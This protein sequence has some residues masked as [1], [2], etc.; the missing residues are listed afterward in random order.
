MKQIFSLKYLI[1]TS[2]GGFSLTSYK[3]F[4]IFFVL[5]ILIYITTIF[6]EKRQMGLYFKILKKVRSFSLSNLLIGLALLFF[7][8]ELIPIL[9]A[10]FWYVI[11]LALMIFWIYLIIKEYLKIPDKKQKIIEAKEFKKYLP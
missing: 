6:L 3:L 2:P 7:S 11:W 9:S 4:A 5:L 8:F 10:R 1:N